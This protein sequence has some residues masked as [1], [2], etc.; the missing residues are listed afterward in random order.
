MT[1]TV[2]S[3]TLNP[4][5][6]NSILCPNHHGQYFNSWSIA[7]FVVS[8]LIWSQQFNKNALQIIMPGCDNE[9][10]ERLQ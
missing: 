4:T 10:R 6:L 2:S 9:V 3:G 5:Q 1:Y 8:W 7:A